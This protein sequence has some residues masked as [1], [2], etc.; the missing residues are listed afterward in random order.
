MGLILTLGTYAA[1][2]VF[3]GTTLSHFLTLWKA[4]RVPVPAAPSTTKMKVRSFIKTAGDILFLKRLLKTN[5]LLW[6]GEWVFHVSFL[7]VVLRHLRY[8]LTPVPGWIWSIQ[9]PGLVAGYIL[10]VSL[11][12]ILLIKWM[13]EGGYFSSYNFFLLVLLF[14]ISTIGLLMK[15]V[16][17]NDI[18]MVKNF[19]IGI[20]SFRPVAPP[21]GVLFT[22]HYLLSLLFLICIPSHIFSAPFVLLDA[23]TR[24]DKLRTL[25]HER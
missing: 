5:D 2:M 17:I 7:F 18:V 16:F 3:L 25:L 8:I 22:V 24:E 4:S 15:T 9:F 14:T 20:I 13:G 19:M 23:Q 21:G 6:I 11:V 1:V 12:F 10:P